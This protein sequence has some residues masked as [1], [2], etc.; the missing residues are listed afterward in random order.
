V[1]YETQKQIFFLLALLLVVGGVYLLLPGFQRG[2]M[3]ECTMKWGRL[4]PFPKIAKNFTIETEGSAFTRTFI[5]S[6]SDT[7]ETIQKWLKDSAGI[8]EGS[9]EIHLGKTHRYILKTGEGAAYGEVRVSTD[10]TTVDFKVS[11]S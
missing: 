2:N 3:I 1:Y 10:G 4:A 7:P 11:W 9:Q 8:Q 6:F 5:G